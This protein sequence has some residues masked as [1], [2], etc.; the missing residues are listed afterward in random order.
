MSLICIPEVELYLPLR[1]LLLKALSSIVHFGRNP[2][3]RLSDL[4]RHNPTYFHPT[5]VQ[6]KRNFLVFL[7]SIFL[8]SCG[9]SKDPALVNRL[10]SWAN[11]SSSKAYNAEHAFKPVPYATGQ[12]VVQLYSDGEE[13]TISKTAIV[14]QD[15]NGWI[16]EL[17]SLS[18]SNESTMQMLVRGMEQAHTSGSVDDVEIVWVK[19]K[20][21]DQDVQTIEG[22]VLALTRGLYRDMLGGM[23]VKMVAGSEGGAVTV[24]AGTFNGTSRMVSEMTFLGKSYSAEGWFHPAVPINGC[25]KSISKENNS[26]MSLIEFG[27]SGAKPSF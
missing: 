2:V 1:F 5:E 8:A 15:S 27:M 24:P 25:V 12:Y 10:Q 4:E 26:V 13:R 23:T 19:M 11:A 17:Y 18:E 3:D 21:K 20:Q 22:P 14:G 9:A 7:V 6:M 16:L